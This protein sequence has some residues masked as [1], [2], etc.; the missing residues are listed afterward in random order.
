MTSTQAAVMVIAGVTYV[1]C[2]DCTPS[3]LDDDDSV[4]VSVA[5]LRR[6][7]DGVV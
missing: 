7:R 4:S 1:L 5:L 2:P 6:L 3:H